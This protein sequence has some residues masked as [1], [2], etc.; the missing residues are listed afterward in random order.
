VKESADSKQCELILDSAAPMS[1]S[2]K[3]D[4]SARD[5]TVVLQYGM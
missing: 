3:E 2:P 1:L 5:G 4:V